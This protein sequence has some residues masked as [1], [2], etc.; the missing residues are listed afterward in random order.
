MTPFVMFIKSEKEIN[1]TKKKEKK[2]I[3]LKNNNVFWDMIMN[4]IKKKMKKINEDSFKS[5]IK[6]MMKP[7]WK[8]NIY[9]EKN[10]THTKK[11]EE[12]I[13]IINNE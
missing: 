5:K 1:D 6:K 3:N 7:F 10:D 2:K 9:I 12:I 11:E 8:K 13:I 4:S